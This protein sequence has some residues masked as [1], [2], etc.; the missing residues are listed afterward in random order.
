MVRV[1]SSYATSEGILYSIEKMKV[2]E[3]YSSHVIDY[4]VGFIWLNDT[5]KFNKNASKIALSEVSP[6]PG[7]TVRTSG[8]GLTQVKLARSELVRY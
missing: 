1:G 5:I 2:H 8:W 7:K 6:E 4:D 3:K